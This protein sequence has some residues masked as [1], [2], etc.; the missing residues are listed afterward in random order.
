[1]SAVAE[2]IFQ[3]GLESAAGTAVAA[4]RKL[5]GKAELPMEED[6]IQTIQQSRDNYVANFDAVKTH[7]QAKWSYEEVLNFEEI[8]FWAQMFAKGSVTP[9]GAGPYVWTF[10]G[11]GS[12]DDLQVMTLEA[13]DN[14]SQ[15]QCPYGI[16]KTWELAGSDG[17]G[18]KLVTFKTEYIFQK[19][20]HM[21]S[22]TSL[23][24]RD[25]T[26]HYGAF[27]NTA[28]YLDDAAGGIGTT[29]IPALMAFTIKCDNKVQPNFPGN[30]NGL[31]TSHNRDKRYVEIMVD[32]LLDATTY[33]E[34]TDHYKDGDAR[35]GRI[36]V[37]G[38]GNDQLDF[39]FHVARWHK[40]EPKAS[41]STRRVVLMAQSY[42]DATLGY[43]WQLAIQNDVSAL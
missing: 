16:C 40:F 12:S 36:R 38:L 27:A 32:L 1:M 19:T 34:F 5:Y 13:A 11:V 37:G 9:T 24:E 2:T 10:N 14:V 17:N 31:Y 20:D 29:E 41:G 28:L 22:L 8:V 6:T 30:Q 3:A 21:G 7:T 26:G 43:D 23:S 39:D 33:T 15:L 42:Y 18:P 25:I 4:T 35:F